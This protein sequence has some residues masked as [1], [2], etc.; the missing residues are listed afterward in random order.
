MVGEFMKSVCERPFS[1]FLLF[2]FRINRHGE[3]GAGADINAIFLVKTLGK[4]II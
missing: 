1:N 2:P 4:R 3:H